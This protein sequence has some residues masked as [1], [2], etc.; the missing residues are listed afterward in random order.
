MF[1]FDEYTELLLTTI[2]P[3]LYH[4]AFSVAIA[5]FALRRMGLNTPGAVPILA[6]AGVAIVADLMGLVWPLLYLMDQNGA[7]ITLWEHPLVVAANAVS[8]GGVLLSAPLFLWG[9]WLT[10][11]GYDKAAGTT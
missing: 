5:A 8:L 9:L 10:W 6:A 4:T 2:G 7:W 3:R 1:G 11:R